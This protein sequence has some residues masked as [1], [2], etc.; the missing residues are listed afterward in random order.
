LY[1]LHVGRELT[2]GDFNRPGDPKPFVPRFPDIHPAFGRLMMKTFRKEVDARFPTDE[3]K[4]D[5]PSGFNELIRTLHTLSRTF[6][7]V[8][9][10]VAAWTTTGMIRTGNEDAF[11]LL[12]ACETRQDDVSE[13]A[14]VLL[15]DGM[16][17]YEAGEVAAALA[18]SVM[19][20][21]LT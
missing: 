12:H 4:K 1:A 21:H 10:E 20:Q 17:G 7:T 3:A 5:D 19:R 14:L 13:S 2:E 6:D 8:R 18:I 9:L 11:A 16:G 15:C